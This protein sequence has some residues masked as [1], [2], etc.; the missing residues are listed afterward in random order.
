MVSKESDIFSL[1]VCL[2]EVLT[3]RLPFTGD[4]A[5]LLL[6][7][8]NKSYALPSAWVPGLPRGVDELVT[9]MLEPEPA[10]RLKTAEDFVRAL[11]S[12]R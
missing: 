10:R 5:G 6:N 9:A 11:E 2:C 12:I 8:M 1:G 3:G 4:G 7:K